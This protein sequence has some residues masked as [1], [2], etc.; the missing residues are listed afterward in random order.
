[1]I[2]L[3]GSS[4]VRVKVT[5][6]KVSKMTIFK[7]CL[8]C[9]FSTNQKIPMVLDTRPKY[10]KSPGLNFLLVTWLQ[11]LQKNR[12]RPIRT[13]TCGK[14]P[15]FTREL[16]DRD[17]GIVHLCTVYLCVCLVCV[18]VGSVLTHQ[19]SGSVGQHVISVQCTS[20]LRLATTC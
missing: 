3:S 20:S 13:R 14:C 4:E 19:L 15:D 5:W 10:L 17:N 9:H 18:W 2:W 6:D 16:N 11:S 12:L 1:M 8:L 7:I